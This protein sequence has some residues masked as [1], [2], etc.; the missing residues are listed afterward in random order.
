MNKIIITFTIF[1][2]Q[3]LFVPAQN[4]QVADSLYAKEKYEQ[5]IYQYDALLKEGENA[6][7]YYNLGNCYYRLGDIAHAILNYERAINR[8]PSDKDAQFNLALARTKT[9][10]KIQTTD[11]FFLVAWFNSLINIMNIDHW[12]ITAIIFMILFLATI[13]I[14]FFSSNIIL[15]KISLFVSIVAF[16]AVILSNLFALMQTNKY[17]DKTQAIVMNSVNVK[18]TPDKSGTVLFE[19][20]D[21]TKV[22]IIDNTMKQWIEISLSDGK[23][24]WVPAKSIETI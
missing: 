15:R 3:S 8:N 14:L 1:I 13:L 17:L 19:L 9:I 18:S 23:E 12:A 4:K 16:V 20:H 21:G 22:E 7:L 24:G 6:K 5:A 11:T 10:D 2:L